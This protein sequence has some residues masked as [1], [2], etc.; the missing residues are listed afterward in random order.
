MPE[1]NNFLGLNFFRLIIHLEIDK[2]SDP[3]IN[4]PVDDFGMPKVTG[5]ER[6]RS[7]KMAARV[8]DMSKFMDPRELADQAVGLNLKLMKWR[9]APDVDLDKI[10]RTKCLLLGA[11]TLGCYV[12]RILMGWNVQKITFV[13]RATVSYSNPVRQ[14]LFEFQDC[15][16]GGKDKATAAAEA[17]KQIYPGVEAEGHVLSV[18]MLGHPVLDEARTK[19]DFEKLKKL[20]DAHDA[21]FLL[22]DSR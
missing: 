21:I 3:V 8:T 15:L 6:S 13:D 10:K 12:A 7:G 2:S 4:E 18:P 5:W 17:L 14:P 20:V 1:R 22:L 16:E 11:G 19:S 9:I